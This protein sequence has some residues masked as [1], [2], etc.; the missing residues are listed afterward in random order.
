MPDG[1]EVPVDEFVDVHAH[2]DNLLEPALV[3]QVVHPSTFNRNTML[4]KALLHVTKVA[5]G[6]TPGLPSLDANI[7][8]LNV[9][10]D[11]DP[12]DAQDAQDVNAM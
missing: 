12:N 2:D 7:A 4:D 5:A 1:D 11:P 6:T 9:L 3:N 8:S 10:R